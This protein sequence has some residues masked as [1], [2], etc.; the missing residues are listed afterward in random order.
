MPPKKHEEPKKKVYFGRP[1]N[2]LKMGIVGLPN[3]GKSTTFNLLTKMNVPAENYPFCTIEPSVAKVAV[4]D[5]RFDRLCQMYKPKSEIAATL[6]ITDIAGLVKGASEGEGLGNE[7]LANIQ[8]VDGIYQMIRGFEDEEIS[9]VEGDV[10]PIRDLEIISTELI[11][12]DKQNLL[13]KKEDLVKQAGRSNN[14]EA[15]DELEI[16]A[17]VEAILDAGKW[18][19]WS[20][21]WTDREI[22][23]I[24]KYYFLT[25]KPSVYLVNLSKADFLAKKNKWLGKIQEW[26]TTHGG[27]PIIPF[28][29]DYEREIFEEAEAMKKE[30]S[31]VEEK[32]EDTRSMVPKIIKTGYKIL[33]LIY[34]FTAGEDEV[35]CWTI[36][37]GT[38][39]PQAGGVIHTDFEKGFICVDSM[40][41]ADLDELG[42]EAKVKAEGK[43]RQHGKEHVIE[44][45]DVLYFKV[46]DI[47][48]GGK[49]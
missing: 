41:Y 12:K 48:G 28:S 2:S 45:G 37:E 18:V 5:A 6:T 30:E 38:K 31:K 14:K 17:K 44:D 34:F 33:E 22:E 20:D 13:K 4:P 25:S 9:H 1:G 35:R 46:G 32:K 26:V 19:R 11:A 43:Y 21:A 40:K 24:N 27:G 39:A 23:V 42:S 3:V 16:I 49:K 15:K 47:K 8:G 29:A 36:R 7:F 10:N